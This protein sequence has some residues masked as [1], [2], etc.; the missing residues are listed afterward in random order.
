MNTLRTYA[1]LWLSGLIAGVVV[2]ERW[3][4][5]GKRL[6]PTPSS[7]DGVVEG[8]A[9]SAAPTSPG[10]TPKV[11]W[12]LVAGAKN[13]AIRVQQLVRRVTPWTSTPAP[14]IP[15]APRWNDAPEPGSSPH[16]SA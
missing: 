8:P 10:G 13:D 4:R 11:S 5:T 14:S 16:G 7:A 12:V 1:I 9:T 3:R 2:M 15:G 6:I